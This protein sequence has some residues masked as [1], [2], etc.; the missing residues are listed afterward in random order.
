MQGPDKGNL[1]AAARNAQLVANAGPEATTQETRCQTVSYTSCRP[2]LDQMSLREQQSDY[3]RVQSTPCALPVTEF[4]AVAR[5]VSQDE[6]ADSYAMSLHTYVAAANKRDVTLGHLV[7]RYQ[8]TS[9]RSVTRRE[10]T[11]PILNHTRFSIPAHYRAAH[12]VLSR[13]KNCSEFLLLWQTAA[14]DFYPQAADPNDRQKPDG[15]V[16]PDV[17]SFSVDHRQGFI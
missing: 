14:L 11:Q 10:K 5:D 7:A 16:V 4:F 17:E 12:V 2:S 9:T 13:A 15:Y 8:L 1:F 3:M 6:W